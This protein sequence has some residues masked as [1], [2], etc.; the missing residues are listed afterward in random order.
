MQ[1]SCSGQAAHCRARLVLLLTLSSVRRLLIRCSVGPAGF[2]SF[3]DAGKAGAA[4][5]AAAGREKLHEVVLLLSISLGH[6]TP[7]LETNSDTCGPA[8]PL[9]PTTLPTHV[10]PLALQD[11]LLV[12]LPLDARR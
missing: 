10:R 1:L 11:F 2:L 4:N 7:S 8:P 6:Q 12:D 5:A 3:A 9:P